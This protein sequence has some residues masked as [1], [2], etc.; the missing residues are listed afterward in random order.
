MNHF[1]FI[2][3]RAGTK[4]LPF[5]FIVIILRVLIRLTKL[6]HTLIKHLLIA[7]IVLVVVLY[8]YKKM[9]SYIAKPHKLFHNHLYTI[10]LWYVFKV[11]P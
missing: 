7:T 5:K 3:L 9:L 2:F 1:T 6:K 10:K 8:N 4:F 11:A